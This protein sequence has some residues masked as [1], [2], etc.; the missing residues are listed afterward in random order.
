MT[1]KKLVIS[2]FPNP[3]PGN[4]YL[5]LLYAAME[6]Q[7]VS[8]RRSGHFGQ[9]WLR[10]HRGEVDLLHFH[11]LDEY[12]G[13]GKGS[14][15]IRRLLVFLTKLLLAKALGY[16]VLWT[17]HNLYPHNRKR[18][19]RAWLAR[20]LFIQLV[21]V[22]LINFPGARDDLAG[23]FWRRRKLVVLPHGNY[24]PVYPEIP[25]RATARKGLGLDADEFVFFLFGGISPYKG[26]HAA[27]EAM[28]SLAGRGK[29]RLVVK[30]QCL[31]R[32]YAKRLADMA[33]GVPGVDL[34][35]GLDDVTDELVCQWMAAVD[36]V[37]APY[38][39]I[40]T[41]GMLYLAATF[42]KSIIAP[43]QAIFSDLGESGFV[44]LYDKAHRDTQLAECMSQVMAASPDPIR[45]ASR[46]F[47]DSH[48]WDRLVAQAVVELRRIV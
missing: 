48:D 31:D 43:R 9:E 5:S 22:I 40:Y 15:S 3:F 24:D 20:F 28:K 25:D 17:M 47:A 16:R 1:E 42:G 38:D 36:C 10:S 7:G 37:L 33:R 30:G 4:P 19:F 11:W 41:S 46:A 32:D 29:V 13:D 12:Y 14:V 23:R 35:L 2:S 39:E 21:D 18:D 34:H 6:K 44:Y 27:I 45:R 26:A 8:Y